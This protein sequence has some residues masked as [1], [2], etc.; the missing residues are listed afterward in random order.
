MLF[1]GG[2]G[3][4]QTKKLKGWKFVSRIRRKL[5]KAMKFLF[6]NLF[7][8]SLCTTLVWDFVK[9]CSK[10]LWEKMLH[11]NGLNIRL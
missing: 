9:E 1:S 7:F 8:N 10:M 4:A 6:F 2:R 3:P 5:K 11:K